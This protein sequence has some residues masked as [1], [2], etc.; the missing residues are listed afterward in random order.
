[1]KP[2]LSES[3]Q[4]TLDRIAFLENC[5][6]EAQGKAPDWII[7]AV[8]ESIEDIRHGKSLVL[9]SKEEIR[10]FFNNPHT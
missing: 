4:A 7:E 2:I 10:Q 9:E 8:T 3:F 1:M 5:K 6:T